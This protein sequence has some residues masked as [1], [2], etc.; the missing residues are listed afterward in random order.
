MKTLSWLIGASPFD[1]DIQYRIHVTHRMFQRNI[2][3]EDVLTILTGGTI[4]ERYDEDFPFPSVLLNGVTRSGRP[5]HLVA[6]I[7]TNEKRIFII[8]VYQPD[9][10]R[11]SDSFTRRHV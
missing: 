9:P 1:W 11:W 5:L 8:T 3:D 7:D 4:I 10:L 2:S 6:G